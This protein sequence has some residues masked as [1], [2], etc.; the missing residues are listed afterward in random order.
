[1]ITGVVEMVTNEV[2]NIRVEWTKGG[3]VVVELGEAV[4]WGEDGDEEAE[5]EVPNSWPL[6]IPVDCTVGSIR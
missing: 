4:T 6:S 3:E 1:M 5:A 2:G